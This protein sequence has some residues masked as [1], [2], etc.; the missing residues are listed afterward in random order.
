MKRL[1]VP[2]RPPPVPSSR[3][4]LRGSGKQKLVDR[5]GKKAFQGE[6][7]AERRARRTKHFGNFVVEAAAGS[8]TLLEEASV[9]SVTRNRYTKYLEE[10]SHFAQEHGLLGLL[11]LDPDAVLTDFLNMMFLEG[12]ELSEGNYAFAAWVWSFPEFGKRGP[13]SLPRASRSLVGWKKM[14]PGWTRPPMPWACLALVLWT[15]LRGIALQPAAL[16]AALILTLMF[17]CYLRPSEPLKMLCTDLLE[18]SLSCPQYAVVLHSE[19]AGSAS[20]VGL[21]NETL[22]LDSV[23][24]PWLGPVLAA[25]RRSRGSERMLFDMDLAELRTFFAGAQ[26]A[27][28]LKERYILYQLRHAG[29]SHDSRFG[30][31]EVAAIKRRGRWAADGSLA[32]YESHGLVAKQENK[33]DVATIKK[34]LEAARELGTLFTRCLTAKP[35]LKLASSSSVPPSSRLLRPASK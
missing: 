25:W 12:R 23:T 35:G 3:V 33:E 20:K 29:P 2:R 1:R 9:T 10:L 21:R 16:Q 30:L 31:R 6:T 32:R 5:R 17:S 34:G 27:A 26:A 15:L 7:Q 4:L 11:R 24:T 14:A 13:R 19:D 8:R 22:L 18:A 28:G